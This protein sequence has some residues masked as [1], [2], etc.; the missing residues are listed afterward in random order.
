MCA[1][2]CVQ[3]LALQESGSV[4]VGSWRTGIRLLRGGDE[5]GEEMEGGKW[6]SE[7]QHAAEKAGEKRVEP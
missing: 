6:A 4:W 7:P 1:Q 2:I 5:G 3:S